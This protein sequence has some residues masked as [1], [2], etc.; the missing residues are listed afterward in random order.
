ADI[1]VTEWHLVENNL[2]AVAR[3][4]LFGIPLVV[5]EAFG[6]FVIRRRAVQLLRIVVSGALLAPLLVHSTDPI[7]AVVAVVFVGMAAAA[8][9]HYLPRTA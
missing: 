8:R 3:S 2:D 1:L 9:L 7:F 5:V 6:L 4:C